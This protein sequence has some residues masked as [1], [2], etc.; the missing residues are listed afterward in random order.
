MCRIRGSAV[1]RIFQVLPLFHPPTASQG[2]RSLKFLVPGHTAS[3]GRTGRKLK[4]SISLML[5]N[6]TAKCC[7]Q[8]RGKYVTQCLHATPL[9]PEKISMRNSAHRLSDC[10]SFSVTPKMVWSH[11]LRTPGCTLTAA[12]SPH[13]QYCA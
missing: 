9:P 13:T 1:L 5:S 3:N 7:T 2:F 6:Y 10:S 11:V 8:A 4:W 12:R